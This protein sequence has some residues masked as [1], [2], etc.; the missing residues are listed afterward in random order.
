MSLETL[1]EAARYVELQEAQRLQQSSS[2]LS[3]LARGTAEEEPTPGGFMS[4]TAAAPPPP[5]PVVSSSQH[6]PPPPPPS[7]PAHNQHVSNGS[8]APHQPLDQPD[9]SK[10]FQ[11]R[12]AGTREVHNKLE[13]NRRAHLK[14]CFE[15]LKRQLPASEDEK[16]SSN[17]SILHSALRHIQ[18][19]FLFRRD[20]WSM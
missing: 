2:S 14:E 15:L 13:K 1:L 6:Q 11:K 19:A 17:L 5:P 18:V 3:S 20:Q 4:F 9:D 8:P 7:R 10:E 16:K 12:A